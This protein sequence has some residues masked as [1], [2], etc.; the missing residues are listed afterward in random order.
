MIFVTLGTQ[1]KDFS[2]LLIEVEKL[3][4]T[5][6]IQDEI[7]AQIGSTKFNSEN[8]TC[9]DYVSGAKLLDYITSCDLLITHGG[10]GSILSGITNDKNVL[11]VARRKEFNEH[12]NNHQIEIVEKFDELE[13]IVGCTSVESLE[14]AYYKSL[15]FQ[16]KKYKENNVNFCILI[17]Q[18]IDAD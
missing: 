14:N 8:M 7:I 5:G 4:K 2:R 15:T 11:A 9:F 16:R 1:D 18:L 13:Y 3:K 17:Q 12:E 10:V 6:V